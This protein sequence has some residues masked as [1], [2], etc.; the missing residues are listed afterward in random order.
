[1]K[2]PIL[3]IASGS[4]I[5]ILGGLLGKIVPFLFFVLFFLV[6]FL[7][8][9][10]FKIHTNLIRI[11]N[12]FVQNNTILLFLFTTI[13]SSFYVQYR[14]A[15]YENVYQNFSSKEW[16]ATIM[17]SPK[18]T[19]YRIIY[20]VKLE[21]YP[22]MYFILHVPKNKKMKLTYGDKVKITGEYHAPE[23]ARNTGGFSYQNY[24]KTQNIYGILEA[25]N[26]TVL[27]H[28]HVHFLKRISYNLKQKI[29]QH[30]HSLLSKDTSE[31][32]LGILIG[33]DDYLQEE[34]VENF[35]KSSLSHLLAVSGAHIAYLV[36][37]L[38]YLLISC[39]IPKKI[40]NVGISFFLLFFMYLVDFS[41][42]V[43]R[44]SFM[45]ILLLC[46]F[47]L[48]RKNDIA[49]TM[50]FSVCLILLY[51][52]FQLL[53]IGLLLSYFAT[54]GIIIFSKLSDNV[55]N[56]QELSI[57][58]KIIVNFKNMAKVCMSANIFIIPII[59]YY[60]N[61]FSLTFL[62][63]NLIAGMLIGPIMIEG[64]LLVF[65]SFLWFPFASFLAKPY[66]LLL[67]ILIK[68]TEV[69]S[70]FPLAEIVVPTPSI[71]IIILYYSILFC[72][73]M[74]RWLKHKASY[75]Y[76]IKK[77]IKL[78][79]KVKSWLYRYFK[80]VC[81]FLLLLIFL[82]CILQKIP[83][84]LKIYFI[85]IGQGD[86]CLVI[87]PTGKKVMIDSGGTETGS[88]DV[89]KSTLMPYLLDRGITSLDYICISHFDS[90]HCKGFI[91][92]LNHM[93]VKNL[94]ISKQYE[95]T[96]NFEEIIHLVNEKKIN[97][98]VVEAGNMLTIDSDIQI[99]IYS[100]ENLLPDIN[101]NSVVMKL[102]YGN[103]SCLFTGDIPQK[104]ENELVKKY[105]RKLKAT[106]LK[107]AH[108]GSKSSSSKEF[109]EVVHPSIALIGVGKNNQ[110][111]HPNEEVI[112]R[113][114]AL[115]HKNLSY[116]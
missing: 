25:T 91:Y 24:L 33:Y 34:I 57:K 98:M 30:M 83:Q 54:I 40:R 2:R 114:K 93:K 84:N 64:L 5:G 79:E 19:N 97:L 37:G 90:D 116:R 73:L 58:E 56:N 96:H 43:V 28:N 81:L 72:Y 78:V 32:C 55:A 71:S 31:L 36:I 7:K 13:L 111:G 9:L 80:I 46:S 48:K 6:V 82:F 45:A 108:H 87:S 62:L 53:D 77:M 1:M 95:T 63:S 70:H 65:L 14:N 11:V 112:K 115:R 69:M 68:G 109:L 105:G 50:S 102:E 27:E 4:I 110:F 103:F 23:V 15:K 35:R 86:S 75:R 47:L 26:C 12:I 39:K 21:E 42:S 94:V 99:K 74:Y 113:L 51:N 22:S 16:I 52:P 49:T 17:S 104:I 92:I 107:V 59:L 20:Q 60:F 8:K 61:T 106:M 76:S 66:Q 41:P 44:A 101:D 67:K 85:D 88:F 10:K 89:G 38:N 100:P 3:I 29:I 18:E